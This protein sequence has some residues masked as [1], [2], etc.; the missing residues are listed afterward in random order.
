MNR[1]QFKYLMTRRDFILIC[2]TL[3]SRLIGHKFKTSEGASVF[4]GANDHWL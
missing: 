1:Y 3:A 2:M 4:L